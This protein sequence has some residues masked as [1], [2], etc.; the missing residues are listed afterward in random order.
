MIHLQARYCHAL[1]G[2]GVVARGVFYSWMRVA[3]GYRF[4][5]PECV[6]RAPVSL[7]VEGVF[8]RRCVCLRNRP[9]PSRSLWPVPCP[10]T[11]EVASV[12]PRCYARSCALRIVLCALAQEDCDG[13][14]VLCV[15][16]GRRSIFASVHFAWQ[17]QHFGGVHVHF[18]WQAQRL[19]CVAL[20]V[21][22]ESHW[23][24]CVKW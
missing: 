9:Q 24:G 4:L 22:C 15:L 6:A 14:V 1:H 18:A 13:R 23:H 2:L 16:Y 20:R 21:F 10:Q 17:A 8:A 7:G 12:V 19:R 3:R 5:I 11:R